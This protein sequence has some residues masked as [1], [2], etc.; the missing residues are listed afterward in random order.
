ME[1]IKNITTN[2]VAKTALF[3]NLFENNFLLNIVFSNLLFKQ[4]NICE[5]PSVAKA[6]VIA[7]EVSEKSYPQAKVMRVITVINKL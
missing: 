6:I 1:N 7:L 5:I 2:K 4:C 3:I